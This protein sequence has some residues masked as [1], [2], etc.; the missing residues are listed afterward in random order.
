M[1]IP[2]VSCRPTLVSHRN[3]VDS[4]G[5]VSLRVIPVVFQVAAM[6][7]APVPH[8]ANSTKVGR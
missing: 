8:A 7:Q 1:P 2:H 4:L 6:H 3:I 5:H